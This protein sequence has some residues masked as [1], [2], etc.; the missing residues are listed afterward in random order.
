MRKIIARYGGGGVRTTKYHEVVVK[1]PRCENCCKIHTWRNLLGLCLGL[2]MM[3]LAG[4][5]GVRLSMNIDTNYWVAGAMI[6]LA[7]ALG[8]GIGFAL[9]RI[10]T[11]LRFR[12]ILTVRKTKS[13]WPKLINQYPLVAGLKEDGYID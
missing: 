11:W 12:D 6:A 10:I 2:A 3:I 7:V 8:G 13:D 5:L 4:Y 1:I 9:A